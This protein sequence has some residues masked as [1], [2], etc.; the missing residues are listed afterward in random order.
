MAN[1]ET[2]HLYAQE[3]QQ[4]LMEAGVLEDLP[5]EYRKRSGGCTHR[6]MY[7]KCDATDWEKQRQAILEHGVVDCSKKNADGSYGVRR[8]YTPEEQKELGWYP[9]YFINPDEMVWSSKWVVDDNPGYYASRAIPTQN[10]I[11]HL[12]Y[13]ATF[14]G[15]WYMKNGKQFADMPFINPTI[16]PK[17][18]LEAAI[19]ALKAANLDEYVNE[20]ANRFMHIDKAEDGRSIEQ[21]Q[22]AV[23]LD[24]VSFK[25]SDEPDEEYLDE[26]D[27]GDYITGHDE[28]MEPNPALP[29]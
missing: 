15:G 28:P 17:H 5:E 7:E 27:D 25:K 14:D 16:N 8:D 11:M 2:H 6:I 22:F 12:Y 19:D 1:Y 29:F 23:V 10:M 4:N 24:Y 26:L 9:V 13:E 18:A 20:M 3:L 21:Q